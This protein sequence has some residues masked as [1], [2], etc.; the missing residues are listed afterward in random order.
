MPKTGGSWVEHYLIHELGGT[1]Y[2]DLPGHAP[3]LQ[4]PEHVRKGKILFGTVRDPLSWYVSWYVHAL[5]SPQSQKRLLVFGAGNTD[6]ESVLRGALFPRYDRCP[7]SPGVIWEVPPVARRIYLGRSESLYTW[8][9]RYVYGGVQNFIPMEDLSN[10][11][12]EF[13][14]LRVD[15]EKYLPR[16]TRSERKVETEVEYTDELRELVLKRDGEIAKLL[17]YVS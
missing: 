5:S 7:D 14:H 9:F 16:N 3:A 11:L 6:F 13:L 17:G 15:T 10:N 1:I 4:I 2:P 12:G 8:A